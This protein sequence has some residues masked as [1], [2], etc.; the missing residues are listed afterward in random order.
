MAS[1]QAPT[2]NHRS[3]GKHGQFNAVDYSARKYRYLPWPK[4]PQIYAVEDGK[5]TSYKPSGNCGNRMEL[6]STDGKRRW[7][8]CHLEKPYVKVG[9]KVKRGQ[10]IGKMGYTGLT[11]PKGEGGRHLH[12]VCYTGGKYVYPPTLINTSFRIYTPTTKQYY[13]VR[14][15]D[16]VGAICKKYGISLARFKVLNPTIKD[17]NKIYPLQRLRVK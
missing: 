15:G 14:P 13:I 1:I 12:L 9:T 8:H 6:V 3:Q 10:L 16:T 11:I 4:R 17:I 5:I 7:G 2:K